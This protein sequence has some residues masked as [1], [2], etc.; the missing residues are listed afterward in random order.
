MPT[1][2]LYQHRSLCHYLHLD[3][4]PSISARDL[5]SA[6]EQCRRAMRH[7]FIAVQGFQTYRETM[8]VACHP[9][10]I[11]DHVPL[12]FCKL[13]SM[14]FSVVNSKNFGR[15]FLVYEGYKNLQARLDMQVSNDTL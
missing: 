3:N 13:S 11:D 10:V 15:Q 12:Y 5:L 2:P 7:Y 14:L 6:N 9:G 1:P 8:R 4:L